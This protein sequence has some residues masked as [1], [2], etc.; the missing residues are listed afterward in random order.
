MYGSSI[1]WVGLKWNKGV[2]RWLGLLF[3]LG[4]RVAHETG[5]LILFPWTGFKSGFLLTIL[6]ATLKVGL[7]TCL[8][9]SG[10]FVAFI[11]LWVLS[12]AL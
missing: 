9:L 3:I 10:P 7:G 4:F 6:V 5:F 11:I 1:V 2:F 12:G 8:G